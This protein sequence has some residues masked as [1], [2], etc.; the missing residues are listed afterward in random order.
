VIVSGSTSGGGPR[1]LGGMFDVHYAYSW[2]L[3]F[4]RYLYKEPY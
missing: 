4:A 2:C 1:D 3:S